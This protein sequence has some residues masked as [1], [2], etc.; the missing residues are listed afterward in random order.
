MDPRT[1]WCVGCL[2][3][4]EEIATWG[5]MGEARRAEVMAALPGRQI[6]GPA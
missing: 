6:G 4:I 1:G 3:T 5:S 2:R